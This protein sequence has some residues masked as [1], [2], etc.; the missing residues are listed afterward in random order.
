VSGPLGPD[1]IAITGGRHLAGTVRTPGDKS[2][3]HRVLLIGALAEGTTTGR[4]LSDGDDVARTAAAVSALGA[5]VTRAGNRVSIEGGRNRLR[6]A[7]TIDCG[8]SGTSMRLL[9]GIV[10]GIPGETTLTGDASLSG[11][12]MD[13]VAEPLSAMGASVTGRGP[14]QLPPLVVGGTALHGIEW[15]PAMAS[16]QVKSA[17]LLAGL[18]ATGDTVVR[19]AIATRLHT[20]EM[21]AAAGADITVEPWGTG[22]SV[23]VRAST[24]QPLDLDVPGDPSQSA[25]W[26]T[27]ACVLPESRVL[28]ERVYA[29]GERTGFLRVLER[30]GASVGAEP[31]G[32]GA[33]DLSAAH[34]PL[35]GTVVDAAEIPSLDEVP[36]LA[37]AA[38]AAT[39]TT[40]FHDVGELT[41]KESDRLAATV[42]L[43]EALGA[44]AR[45]E[46][47]D[48]VIEGAGSIGAGPLHFDSRG[49]HRLAMAAIVAA[50]GRGGVVEGVRSVGTSYPGFLDDLETL[51]GPG[52]WVSADER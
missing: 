7:A 18:G 40:V 49:D 47:E 16:A 44:R 36:I 4:G 12:P 19:E 37:V 51:A 17:I 48:L 13:R 32:E 5:S 3:S 1:R 11:R 28:V 50:L 46:G 29:G 21:L 23:R 2:I 6:T 42:A 22:R 9:A 20:E 38:A 45:A 34:S 10:A 35:V 25:F 33:A 27:A 52:A 43:V 30:M 26:I 8:N 31:R 39:G 41:V 15:T 14:R 24:L